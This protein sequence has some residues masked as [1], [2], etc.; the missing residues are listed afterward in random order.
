MPDRCV[1]VEATSEQAAS[2][3]L[4]RAAW[5]EKRR[6]VK[7]T[8]ARNSKKDKEK[9]DQSAEG[10]EEVDEGSEGEGFGGGEGMG[11][12]DRTLMVMGVEEDLPVRVEE[13]VEWE[14]VEWETVERETV[15]WDL[16]FGPAAVER[17]VMMTDIRREM[18]RDRAREMQ[19]DRGRGRGRRGRTRDGRMGLRAR[20]LGRW[21]RVDNV[22]PWVISHSA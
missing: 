9:R 3:G 2:A 15:E 10:F 16:K 5:S 7:R 17:A 12:C 14:T 8:M 18:L 11:Q 13:T 22:S 4:Q 1:K 19:R 21:I 6:V 20:V